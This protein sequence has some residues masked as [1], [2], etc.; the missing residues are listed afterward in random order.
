MSLWYYSSTRTR[1]FAQQA[2]VNLTVGC[3]HVQNPGEEKEAS[4]KCTSAKRSFLVQPLK[5]F[6]R[7]RIMC[8][9]FAFYPILDRTVAFTR[10]I[11]PHWKFGKCAWYAHL[12]FA[13][14]FHLTWVRV[15]FVPFHFITVIDL[16]IFWYSFLFFFPF[17]FIAFWNGIAYIRSM[18][19]LLYYNLDTHQINCSNKQ[20]FLQLIVAFRVMVLVYACL[21]V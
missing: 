15:F 21:C 18:V 17:H 4:H 3:M 1:S 5:S 13:F 8:A 11:V 9:A 16:F 19:R 20:Q 6:V 10:F 2:K 7:V 14:C 12:A